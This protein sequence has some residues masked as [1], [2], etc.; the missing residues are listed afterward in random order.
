MAMLMSVCCV[1]LSPPPSITTRVLPRWTKYMRLVMPV[2][3]KTGGQTAAP[4]KESDPDFSGLT[5]GFQKPSTGAWPT[6]SPAGLI[7]ATQSSVL[8][9]VSG[10]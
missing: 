8:L 5:G 6:T 4:S 7:K 2:T 10:R 1:D 3:C 9:E